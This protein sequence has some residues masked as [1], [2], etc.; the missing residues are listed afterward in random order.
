MIFLMSESSTAYFSG[1]DEQA[2]GET[3]FGEDDRRFEVGGISERK[4]KYPLSMRY[5][6]TKSILSEV[7]G[8]RTD[9][10]CEGFEEVG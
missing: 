4:G 8:D 1:I 5:F 2:G 9:R 7:E 6:P 10:T 3:E